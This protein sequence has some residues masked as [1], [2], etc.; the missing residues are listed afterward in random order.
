MAFATQQRH[1][2]HFRAFG[3]TGGDTQVIGAKIGGIVDRR[4]HR[5]NCLSAT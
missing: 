4:N 5:E 2:S 1:A 3:Q